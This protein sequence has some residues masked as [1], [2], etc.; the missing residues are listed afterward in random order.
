VVPARLA[1]RATRA[2]N[3]SDRRIVVVDIARILKWF[4]D[5]PHGGERSTSVPLPAALPGLSA[6]AA[7][8]FGPVAPA[9]AVV[10]GGK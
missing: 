10:N 4:H 1:A 9:C 3:A 5:S 8:Y 2:F 7:N 6:H